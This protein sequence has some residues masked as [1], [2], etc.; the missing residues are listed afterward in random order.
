MSNGIAAAYVFNRLDVA[1]QRA[2]GARNCPTN[3]LVKSVS[4]IRVEFSA[5]S[6]CAASVLIRRESTS[7]CKVELV[8]GGAPRRGDRDV[9]FSEVVA[10]QRDLTGTA[11]DSNRSIFLETRDR[12]DIYRLVRRLVVGDLFAA[13]SL[14]KANAQGALD[15]S[16]AAVVSSD[17][18]VDRQ[19]AQLTVNLF[20][21]I[22]ISGV[23]CEREA[24]HVVG[25]L[26]RGCDCYSR[27]AEVRRVQL[28]GT[29]FSEVAVII[30]SID[31]ASI[32]VGGFTI[33]YCETFDSRVGDARRRL[34]VGDT[35]A[36]VVEL[37]IGFVVVF[38]GGGGVCFAVADNPLC[39][40]F[41]LINDC[42]IK[43]ELVAVG[44]RGGHRDVLCCERV[45]TYRDD[46]FRGVVFNKRRGAA[47]SRYCIL[48]GSCRRR[49]VD[50]TFRLS[51]TCRN[52][53][54]FGNGEV[55]VETFDRRYSGI[56]FL[57]VGKFL[58]P[59]GGIKV[60][61]RE[62]CRRFLLKGCRALVESPGGI[63]GNTRGIS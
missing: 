30:F 37:M 56:D 51:T 53:F 12:R 7:V 6:R 18:I 36:G 1:F 41:S 33:K 8:I 19:R 17:Q 59:V 63:I 45:L 61:K 44:L 57:G 49:R 34:K 52:I 42:R 13:E 2:R 24:V 58:L 40:V 31:T 11:V 54:F 3:F 10:I 28:K 32:E 46:L 26:K 5:S 22:C 15:D 27:C 38:V 48:A 23:E 55:G 9:L 4:L 21:C 29:A 14:R 16:L 39:H 47:D 25:I 60:A 20:I 43:R 62:A 35:R 50:F